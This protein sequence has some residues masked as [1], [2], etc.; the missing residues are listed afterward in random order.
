MRRLVAEEDDAGDEAVDEVMRH[1]P[2]KALLERTPPL[3][4]SLDGSREADQPHVDGEVS[5]T[6]CDPGDNRQD[7]A[8]IAMEIEAVQRK[9]AHGGKRCKRE[10]ADV[11]E[12]MV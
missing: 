1:E 12:D 5:Q 7:P 3:L 11:E 8:Q 2:G 10:G 4:V 6:G 9:G